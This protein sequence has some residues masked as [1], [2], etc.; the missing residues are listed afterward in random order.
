LGIEEFLICLINI[1][2]VHSPIDA[3]ACTQLHDDRRK[4]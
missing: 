2:F 1:D 4:R 3:I